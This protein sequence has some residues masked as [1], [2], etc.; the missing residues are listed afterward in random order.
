MLHLQRVAAAWGIV[1]AVSLCAGTASAQVPERV[2]PR[3]RP[4]PDPQPVPTWIDQVFNSQYRLPGD[5]SFNYEGERLTAEQERQIEIA[6]ILAWQQVR[7]ALQYLQVNARRVLDGNDP[8][9]NATFGQFYDRS[10]QNPLLGEY[11]ID[12]PA[13]QAAARVVGIADV[14]GTTVS[15]NED[16][17]FLNNIR[18]GDRIVIGDQ[19]HVVADLEI[20]DSNLDDDD[21]EIQG[22]IKRINRSG[23]DSDSSGSDDELPL[24]LLESIELAREFD[25]RDGAID[26]S[27]LDVRRVL[28]TTTVTNR[29]HYERVV[30]TFTAIRDLLE[31]DTEYGADW[32]VME[33]SFNDIYS[34]FDEDNYDPADGAP[35]EVF[36][37]EGRF[38]DRSFRQSG[39]SNSNSQLHRDRLATDPDNPLRWTE[40]N[41]R[42][43][44]AL[45]VAVE[46]EDL[47][48][49]NDQFTIFGEFDQGGTTGTNPQPG[50]NTVYVGGGFLSEN[51][52]SAG[53]LF[54]SRRSD[55][56]QRTDLL[57]YQMII[58]AFAEFSPFFRTTDVDSDGNLVDSVGAGFGILDILTQFGSPNGTANL[59][60]A[61]NADAEV[62]AAF[63]NIFS[64]PRLHTGIGDGTLLPPAGKNARARAENAPL[65]F[66]FTPVVPT[67]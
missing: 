36:V 48:F 30:N 67:Q 65:I 64:D 10:D 15:F 21:E 51:Q 54:D 18:I 39:Y 41:A 62:Y 32:E 4:T 61:Q 11:D 55:V 43:L 26:T 24:P 37:Y 27:E 3:P 38:Y 13:V 44:D 46:G 52:R 47:I 56:E 50:T 34:V 5:V 19:I 8:F 20:D 22:T 59:P 60:F 28:G 7:V 9:Y 35:E 45:G 25:D 29:E 6:H 49:F 23:E 58:A 31:L 40:D 17:P 57:Q 1:L 66:T 42:I 63:A 33:T 16:T 12:V 14:S 2:E 53:G